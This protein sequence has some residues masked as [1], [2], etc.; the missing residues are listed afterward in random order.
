M[1]RIKD[2]K[3]RKVLRIVVPFILIPLTV[4]LGVFVFREKQY[5][6]IS[7]ACV[8]LALLLFYASFDKRIVGTRRLVIIAVMTALS[9]VGRSVFA[10]I[11]MFK[12]ITAIVVITAI[13]IGP[14]SGF[15][16]GSLSAVISNF[17]FGQGPWTPFQMFAWGMI[18]RLAGY[19]RKPL[20]K[21]RVAL[22]V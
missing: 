14:E 5:A 10:L 18:G 1:I 12:P 17:Q 20:K 7:I 3:L 11:P 22:A 16:V 13:W 2:P 15:L 19:L 21:S 4:W 9:V 8:I 6:W